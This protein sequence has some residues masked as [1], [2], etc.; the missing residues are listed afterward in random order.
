MFLAFHTKLAAKKL[1]NIRIVAFAN[2]GTDGHDYTE[3]TPK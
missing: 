3:V 2:I 1:S